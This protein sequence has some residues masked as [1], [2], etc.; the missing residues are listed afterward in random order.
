MR[1]NKSLK[2]DLFTFIQGQTVLQIH[3]KKLDLISVSL[4]KVMDMTFGFKFQ[5]VALR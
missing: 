1:K 2:G 4:K 5:M 3:K